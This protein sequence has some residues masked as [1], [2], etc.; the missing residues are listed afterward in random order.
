MV[1]KIIHALRLNKIPALRKLADFVKGTLRSTALPFPVRIQGFWIKGPPLMDVVAGAYEP[2][3]TKLIHKLVRPG[4][5]FVDVG[6]D[7]GYYSLLVAQRSRDTA[8]VYA[9]EP[10]DERYDQYLLPNIRRN[11]FKNI[12]TYMTALS[13]TTDTITFYTKSGSIYNLRNDIS[14][15]AQI[16]QCELLDN[17]IPS[18]IRVDLVKIDVEAGEIKVLAGMKRILTA[19]RDICLIIEINPGVLARAGRSANEISSYLSG[20]GFGAYQIKPDGSLEQFDDSGEMLSFA[21]AH[22]YANVLFKRP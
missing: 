11:G 15:V 1:K 13:D 22:K 5:V 17:S 14:P 12:N 9:F 8:T 21:V 2:E 16:V 20:L 3:T 4:F 19:N 6:A 7:Y 10:S 18:G